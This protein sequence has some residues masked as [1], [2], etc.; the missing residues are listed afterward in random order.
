MEKQLLT[1]TNDG[2]PITASPIQLAKSHPGSQAALGEQ[3]AAEVQRDPGTDLFLWAIVQNNKEL[4]EIAWEQVTKT[5]PSPSFTS[6]AT[7]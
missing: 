3:E 4:A 2:S 5:T 7:R 1:F 6:S